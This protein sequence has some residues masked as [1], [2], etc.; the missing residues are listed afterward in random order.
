VLD[1]RALPDPLEDAAMI[2]RLGRS[3]VAIMAEAD[4]MMDVERK[5]FVMKKIA[6]LETQ[7]SLT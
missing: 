3:I 5:S 6:E 2:K 4:T 1:V 7:V